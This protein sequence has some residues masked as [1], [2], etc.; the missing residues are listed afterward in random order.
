MHAYV[1]NIVI[2]L[3]TTLIFATVFDFL[4]ANNVFKHAHEK[5]CANN[6]GAYAIAYTSTN[7]ATSFGN[8]MKHKISSANDQTIIAGNQHV[9][10]NIDTARQNNSPT[11]LRFFIPND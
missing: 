9:H 1:N 7:F 8:F 5:H 4:H 6:P 2:G 11:L 3:L 10:T